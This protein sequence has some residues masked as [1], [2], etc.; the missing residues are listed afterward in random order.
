[1]AI[2]LSETI[3]TLKEACAYF[4][5]TRQGKKAHVSR[6]YRY[7]TRGCRGV[8]L[9]SV[10]C[11]ATRCTS[12]RAIETFFQRLTAESGAS[13]PADRPEGLPSDTDVESQLDDVLGK[14]RGPPR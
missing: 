14:P 2:S 9:E 8:V 12:L 6:L 11:G 5:A 4:P 13:Q 1:M 3:V 7:T 10:Q